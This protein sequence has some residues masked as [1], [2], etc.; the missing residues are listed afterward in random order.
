MSKL[1]DASRTKSQLTLNGA[2]T[3]ESS[4]NKNVDLF[5]QIGTLRKNPNV[6]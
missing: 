2:V 1:F 3:H 4:L 6:V 5:F